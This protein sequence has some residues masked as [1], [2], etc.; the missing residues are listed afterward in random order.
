ME[1][2]RILV[3]MEANSPLTSADR[4]ELHEIFLRLFQ[5]L[6][7]NVP[8]RPRFKSLKLEFSK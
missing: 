4:K 3:E 5:P 7:G 2:I 6:A 8:G 1:T